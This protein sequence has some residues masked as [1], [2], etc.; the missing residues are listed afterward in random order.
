MCCTFRWILHNRAHLRANQVKLDVVDGVLLGS[1]SIGIGE[2]F[3]GGGYG[4]GGSS[5]GSNKCF[6]GARV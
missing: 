3:R 2:G 1:I 6:H 4:G 5:G